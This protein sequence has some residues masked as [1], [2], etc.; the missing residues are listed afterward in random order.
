MSEQIKTKVVKYDP[1]IHSELFFSSGEL[2][3]DSYLYNY[4]VKA[5]PETVLYLWINESSQ[6]LGFFALSSYA[7][8]IKEV[9]SHTKNERN[10]LIP[11]V[12]IKA[13]ALSA[14]FQKQIFPGTDHYYSDELLN[15]A[16]ALIKLISHNYIGAEY[17]YLSALNT[18]KV[19]SFYARNGFIQI[20]PQ[21]SI[22]SCECNE[23][24]LV[25]MILKFKNS[26]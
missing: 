16:L 17:V 24:D 10:A 1:Q 22:I 2:C 18:E 14:F 12:Q 4:Y 3:V 19:K 26:L 7:Y 9:D 21:K 6:V 15:R 5:D 11:A 13:F 20:D 25:P 23:N 8:V